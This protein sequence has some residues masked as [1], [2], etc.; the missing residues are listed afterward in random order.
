MQTLCFPFVTFRSHRDE[1]I[2]PT[3][4]ARP[5]LWLA[6][7]QRSDQVCVIGLTEN[8]LCPNP[9]QIS[10]TKMPNVHILNQVGLIEFNHSVPRGLGIF[11]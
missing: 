4:F 7:Y 11:V 3:E 1:R 5:T 6:Y 10:P 8:M 9:N 2:G